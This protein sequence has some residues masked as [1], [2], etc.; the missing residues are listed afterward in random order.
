MY[1]DSIA[2]R[3]TVATQVRA[4]AQKGR[5]DIQVTLND[6]EGAY[7]STYTTKDQLQGEASITAP[8]DARFDE[9]HLTLEGKIS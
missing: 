3:N 1:T 9:V 6:Q 2:T 4:F 7:I 8:H 5:P